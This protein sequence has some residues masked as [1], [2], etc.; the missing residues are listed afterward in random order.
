[1]CSVSVP[2]STEDLN[3]RR[4][5]PAELIKYENDV[6]TLLIFLFMLCT[7]SSV[8]GSSLG[9]FLDLIMWQVAK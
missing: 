6:V 7:F 8:T 1:M 5:S 2:V 9:I 4:S 3:R